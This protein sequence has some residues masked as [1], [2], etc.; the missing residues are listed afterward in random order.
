MKKE[1]LEDLIENLGWLRLAE[2]SLGFWNN[3]KDSVYDLP[4]PSSPKK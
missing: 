4:S 2:S 3:E 1:D